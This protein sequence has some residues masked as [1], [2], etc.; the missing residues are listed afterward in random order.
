MPLKL[1]A[2]DCT[3]IASTVTIVK[4]SKSADTKHFLYALSKD[5]SVNSTA[6]KTL[7][8]YCQVLS[9]RYD[10]NKCTAIQYLTK[11]TYGTDNVNLSLSKRCVYH[12]DSIKSTGT[13]NVSLS[14]CHIIIAKYE[15]Q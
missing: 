8:C 1:E 6:T 2:E 3:T 7:L 12:D 14:D 13:K 4:S 5:D 9:A 10:K 15:H 11:G